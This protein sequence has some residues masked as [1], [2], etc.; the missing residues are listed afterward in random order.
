MISTARLAEVFVEIAD[1]LVDD[2]D[3]ID[4]LHGITTHAAEMTGSPAVGVLLK[5]HDGSLNHVAAST[6]DAQLLEL[7]QLQHLEGPCV[8]C[9]RTGLPV[10]TADLTTMGERWPRFAPRA[11]ETGI[12]AVHAF[13]LR[14]RDTVIGALNVFGTSPSPLDAVD[15]PVVQSLADVSTIA[16]LQEQ[17]LARAEVLTEQLQFAL[18]SRVAIEQ[19]KGAVARSLGIGVEPAFEIIRAHARRQRIGL[20]ELAIKIVNDRSAMDVL[21]GDAD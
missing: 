4:F 19:A 15:I 17:A 3:L 5:S 8:D 1:T 6:E 18:N 16:I 10:F 21:L 11:A 14:L 13:P 7:F 12:R 9:V 2:F 20:T